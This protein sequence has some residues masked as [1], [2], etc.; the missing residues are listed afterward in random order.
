MVSSRNERLAVDGCVPTM[1]GGYQPAFDFPS[2][3]KTNESK[4]RQWL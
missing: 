4:Q 1:E 2:L 3:K